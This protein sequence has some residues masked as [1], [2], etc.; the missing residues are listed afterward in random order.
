VYKHIHYNKKPIAEQPVVTE[1]FAAKRNTETN[2]PTTTKMEI[3]DLSIL[4]RHVQKKYHTTD[5]LSLKDLQQKTIIITCMTTMWRPSSDIGCLQYRGILFKI[6]DNGVAAS[7]TIHA[8]QP[9]E[10]QVKSIQ[11]GRAKNEEMCPVKT[12]Y[13]FTQKS[14]QFREGLPEDH[15]LFFDLSRVPR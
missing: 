8:R 1:F 6:D 11:L 4:I 9:K 3:W 7:V 15:T 10:G 5:Q 12:L 2:I 13:R 14:L